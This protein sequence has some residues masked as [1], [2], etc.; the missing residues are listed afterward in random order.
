MADFLER[1]RSGPPIVADGGMGALLAGATPGLRCPEEANLRAPESVVAVHA[2]Y[3]RAG[4][5]L[6]ETNTFGANRRKLAAKLL[7]HEFEAINSAAVRLAREARDVSGRDVLIAGSIGPLGELEVFDPSEHGPL[8]AEQAQVLEGRGVDLFMIET[9]FDLDELVSAV[10]AVRG[11]SSL[12]IVAL[13]TFDDDAE[14]AGGIDASAAAE[15]LALL[16]VAAIGTNHGAGPH[17]ALT[18]LD[19]DARRRA[20]RWRRCRTS[21]SRASSAGA[22]CT[23]TRPPSTSATSPRRRSRSAPASWAAAA[24]R[25]RP[26]SRRSAPRSTTSG[27]R[28]PRSRRASATSRR[29]PSPADGETGLARAL[30]EGEWVVSVELDPPKGG[31]NDAMIARG[32]DAARLGRRRLRRRERQPDGPGAG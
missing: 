16:D 18:A 25:R 15:R 14:A 27:P 31:T 3:I 32:A 19:R 10:E 13:L 17:A 26:R 28:G 20:C 5:E 22:S 2:S 11:V 23:R 24:A 9:F 30:R 21:G 7:E 4:A 29:R 12:P 6:I 1:L 8:Y